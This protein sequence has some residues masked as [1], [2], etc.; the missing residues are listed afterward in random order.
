MRVVWV[1][2]AGSVGA[3][4]RYL[5]GRAVGPQ[6]FPWA[7]LVIN[8]SGSFALAFVLTFAVQRNWS[9]DLSTAVAVGFLGA[10]TTFSTFMFESFVMGRTERAGSAVAYIAAS[11]ALG[12]LAALG[13]YRLA[14]ALG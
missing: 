3:I 12:L 6:A 2:I 14:R 5:I 1:G 10:Y 9:P 4:A 7:T 8:V 13:G 11:V